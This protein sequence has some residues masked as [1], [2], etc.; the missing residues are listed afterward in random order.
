MSPDL[1]HDLIWFFSVFES[2][3]EAI[4]KQIPSDILEELSEEYELL[5]TSVQN[6]LAEEDWC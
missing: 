2:R 4:V 5:K 6:R 3:T 1:K